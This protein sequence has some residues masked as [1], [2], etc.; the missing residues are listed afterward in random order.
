MYIEK[1]AEDPLIM[2]LQSLTEENRKLLKKI[3]EEKIL[4]RK[5]KDRKLKDWAGL[6]LTENPIEKSINWGKRET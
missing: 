6:I 2:Q 3:R 4:D 1:S 5:S